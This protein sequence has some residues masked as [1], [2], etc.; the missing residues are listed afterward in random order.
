M[1]VPFVVHWQNKSG[2][3]DIIT[4]GRSYSFSQDPLTSAQTFLQAF[5]GIMR[6][7][8]GIDEPRE[9][10][11]KTNKKISYARFEEFYEGIPVVGGQYAVTVLPGGKIQA[12]LGGFFKNIAVGNSPKLSVQQALSSA[13][14]NPPPSVSL[15]DSMASYRLVV[16]PVDTAYRLAWK[17]QVPP[18]HGIGEWIYDIDASAGVVLSR[19][20]TALNGAFAAMLPP[21]QGS[22]YLHHPFIDPSWTTVN[23]V[24]IDNSGYLEGTYANVVNDAT[25]R[26]YSASVD[27]VYDPTDT[28]FDEANLFYHISDFRSNFW[29]ALGFSAFT[30]I[31]AHAHTVFPSPNAEYDGSTGQ[32]YFSDG[33][34]VT[35]FND[36]A[37]EDKVILHEYTHAVTHH[38]VDLA[39][40]Y[41]ETGA[42]DEGNSDYFAGTYTGR[43]LINEYCCAGYPSL[44]RNM[45]DPKIVDYA[46]YKN[47]QGYPSVEPHLGSELW[48]ATLWDLR[49]NPNVGEYYSDRDIFYGLYG[50]P[51]NSSFLQYR[52]AIINADYN[53]FGGA[54]TNAIEDVFAIRGFGDPSTPS[55]AG[56]THLSIGQQ[57]TWTVSTDWGSGSYS[58]AWYLKSNSTNGQ[59]AEMGTGSSY[60]TTMESSDGNTGLQCNV[61]AQITRDDGSIGAIQSAGLIN[62]VCSDYDK[63][64]KRGF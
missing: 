20:S 43:T 53:Y 25:S 26:A 39:S 52:Q 63:V 6:E 59:W 35:G 31:T 62:V 45:A 18:A 32:L 47:Q 15:R 29:N 7:R 58:Y 38:V 44:Q 42:I 8:S 40:G 10:N 16:F 19:R 28:H 60:S 56:P 54:H 23:L 37:K 51:T 3:A 46:E 33:Q 64:K 12:A 27:F 55:I 13:L 1:T 4:F 48:S 50:I 24:Y 30:Q 11:L 36:F 61:T 2:T 9:Q 34:G 22:V 21:P 5:G 49:S 57:G 14:Q 41:N 17:I